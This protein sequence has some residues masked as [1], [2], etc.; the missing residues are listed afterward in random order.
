MK[1]LFCLVVAS[2]LFAGCAASTDADAPDE[3]AEL[4]SDLTLSRFD[5]RALSWMLL[6]NTFE[7]RQHY[8][9]FTLEGSGNPSQIS[10]REPSGV[11]S[12]AKVS[13]FDIQ[14]TAPQLTL[15]LEDATGSLQNGSLVVRGYGNPN[16]ATAPRIF[17][18]KQSSRTIVARQKH[19]GTVDNPQSCPRI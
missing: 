7:S 2:S 4:E 13:G 16:D 1:S 11:V 17:V 6:D 18:F 15:K 9:R 3:V 19:C 12:R 10:V 5:A 14:S 8:V